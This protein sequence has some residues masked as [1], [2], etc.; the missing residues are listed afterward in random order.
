MPT[1]RTAYAIA[2]DWAAGRKNRPPLVLREDI[3][4]QVQT[5]LTHGAD[6]EYLRRLAYWMAV[7][8]PSWFDLSL[9]MRMSAAP[10]PEPSTAP[11]RPP[12]C[13]CRGV[14]AERKEPCVPH[15]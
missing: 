2:A 9:A 12:R 6:P 7:H 8:Q 5:H 1:S 4:E 15:T 10:Q 3:A 11:G 13:P 14:L